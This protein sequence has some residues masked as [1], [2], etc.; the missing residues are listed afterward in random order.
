MRIDDLDHDLSSTAD[1]TQ[2]ICATVDHAGYTGPIRQHGL[3]HTR[4]GIDLPY[5]ADLGHEL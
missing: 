2:Q 5:L 3:D 1:P 4:S